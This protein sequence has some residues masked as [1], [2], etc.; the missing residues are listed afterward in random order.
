MILRSRVAFHYPIDGD[1]VAQA[2]RIVAG[3]IDFCPSAFVSLTIRKDMS[4]SDSSIA[5][6]AASVFSGSDWRK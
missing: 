5:I 4:D 1:R 2:L 6:C 3:S